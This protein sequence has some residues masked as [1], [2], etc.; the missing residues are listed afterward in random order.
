[1]DRS[2]GAMN[3]HELDPTTE[4]AL[5]PGVKAITADEGHIL[6]NPASGVW[7]KLMPEAGGVLRQVLD[8]SMDR[9]TESITRQFGGDTLSELMELLEELRS[10]GLLVRTRLVTRRAKDK[11]PRGKCGRLPSVPRKVFLTVT[12][13]CNLHCSTCYRSEPSQDADTWEIEHTMSRVHRLYPDE[14]VVTGGEPTLRDDLPQLLDCI[15]G[16]SYAYDKVTLATNATLITRELAQTIADMQVKVQVSV[17]SPDESAHD[18]I[19]GQ[20]SFAAACRGLELLAEAEVENVEVVSTLLDPAMFVPEEMMAFA[21]RY[22]AAFHASLFQEVGRGACGVRR[23]VDDDDP[24][25]LARSML[26]YLIRKA[27]DGAIPE[28]TPFAGIVGMAPKMGCGVGDRVVAVSG[29]GYAYPCHLLMV[30]EFRVDLSSIIDSPDGMRTLHANSK[31]AKWPVSMGNRQLQMDSKWRVPDV[32]SI[33]SCQRCDVR[34]FCGGG[35]RAAAYG[36]TGDIGGR[37]PNCESYRALISC[38]LWA[39]DDRIPVIHNLRQARH[40]L[41]CMLPS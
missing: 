34:Y 1:M 10:E 38:L 21:A 32:D 37:D 11:A 23:Q 26:G 13:R 16:G 6:L 24:R 18:A 8:V 30:P 36:A 14:V 27:E 25:S 41:G 5:A 3:V 33:E 9:V 19:R 12:D 39:W 17:E 28:D 15:C 20:G 35:C 31:S 7:V 40:R 29:K 22:G 4:Y 2:S